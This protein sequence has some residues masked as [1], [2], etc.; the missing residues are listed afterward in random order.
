ARHR[1]ARCDAAKANLGNRRRLH[2]AGKLLTQTG[3]LRLGGARANE[4]AADQ[5]HAAI[6]LQDFAQRADQSLTKTHFL[7]HG[8]IT[9]S[10]ISKVERG[11]RIRERTFQRESRR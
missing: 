5:Y 9:S 2:A 8:S 6:L 3:E 10:G 11:F 7:R 1:R 4:T